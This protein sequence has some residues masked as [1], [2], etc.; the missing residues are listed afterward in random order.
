M[1][2]KEVQWGACTVLV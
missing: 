1:D 2:L